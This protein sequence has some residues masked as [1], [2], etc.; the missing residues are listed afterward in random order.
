M[1]EQRPLGSAKR[2]IKLL[3]HTT[4]E[5]LISKTCHAIHSKADVLEECASNRK[6]SCRKSSI[7]YLSIISDNPSKILS[8][9]HSDLIQCAIPLL[10]EAFLAFYI[11][12][13]FI[14][15]FK[16][17]RLKRSTFST[18]SF[19]IKIPNQQWH[20]LTSVISL[21]HRCLWNIDDPHNCCNISIR[22]HLWCY[23]DIIAINILVDD[24][25]LYKHSW[26]GE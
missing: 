4:K 26:C 20:L 18:M 25:S 7:I 8:T 19:Q 12:H 5:I 13:P 9:I 21:L 16:R 24:Q 23:L 17:R 22:T 6:L 1:M 15:I 10:R 3:L 14:L 2:I 11:C